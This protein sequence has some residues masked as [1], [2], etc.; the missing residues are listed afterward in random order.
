MRCAWLSGPSSEQTPQQTQK[1]IRF[2]LQWWGEAGDVNGGY[3]AQVGLLRTTPLAG[4]CGDKTPTTT[5]MHAPWGGIKQ[6][7]HDNANQ[8]PSM[9]HQ[10]R[11]RAS[12]K[13]VKKKKP[14]STGSHMTQPI[15]I[16]AH[17]VCHPRPVGPAVVACAD[18]LNGP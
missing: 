10:Q 5:S 12:A 17:S 2:T 4:G 8:E 13:Q 11:R 18:M 15:D 9:A 3:A 6:P 14:L 1:H 7:H 16:H